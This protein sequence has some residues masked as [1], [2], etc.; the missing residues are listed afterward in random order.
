MRARFCV[1]GLLLAGVGG[2]AARGGGTET[3]AAAPLPAQGWIERVHKRAG[4]EPVFLVMGDAGLVARTPGGRWTETVASAHV[5]QALLDSALDLVWVVTGG[6]LSVVDLRAAKPALTVIATRLPPLAALTITV[7]G[8]GQPR[9]LAWPSA[10]EV[11]AAVNLRWTR[12]PSLEVIAE[13]NTRAKLVGRAWLE[14]NVARPA[15]R[16]L[17]FEEIDVAGKPARL[18]LAR[19]AL[20][21]D[22]DACGHVLPFGNAGWQLVLMGSEAGG[23]C[24]EWTCALYD[25]RRRLFAKPEDPRRWVAAGAVEPGSCGPFAFDRSGRFYLVGEQLCTVGGACS[26]LG[27]Q[28]VGWLAPGPWLGEPG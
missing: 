6:R 28:G 21:C 22:S 13:G 5:D 3:P 26:A 23:D 24:H 25:P 17:P 8:E 10:C 2:G 1:W 15:G 27:G 14:K 19:D 7:D 18:P 4:D 20:P 11:G 9:P 16:P 12:A